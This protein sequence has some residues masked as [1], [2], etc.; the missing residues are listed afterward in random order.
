MQFPADAH[1][2]KG[3]YLK[4]EIGSALAAGHAQEVINF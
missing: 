4:V 2:G 3:S 1:V